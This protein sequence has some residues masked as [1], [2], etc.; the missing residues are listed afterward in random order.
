MGCY[1]SCGTDEC[2]L[3]S[4]SI[5]S[6]DPVLP[7][8]RKLVR[9]ALLSSDYVRRSNT[10]YFQLSLI[11]VMLFLHILHLYLLCLCVCV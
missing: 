2:N 1:E 9:A 5:K 6:P 11:D 8:S 7:L 4:V 3:R 10:G